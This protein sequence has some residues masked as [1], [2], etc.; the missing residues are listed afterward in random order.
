MNL[1]RTNRCRLGDMNPQLTEFISIPGDEEMGP[2][3]RKRD[4][5]HPSKQQMAAVILLSSVFLNITFRDY[6]LVYPI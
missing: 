3:T 5:G 4:Y 1:F 2:V 6:S